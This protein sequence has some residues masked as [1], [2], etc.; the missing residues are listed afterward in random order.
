MPMMFSMDSMM[1]DSTMNEN[2][3]ESEA[4]ESM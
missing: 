2:I 1:E 3:P 4:V